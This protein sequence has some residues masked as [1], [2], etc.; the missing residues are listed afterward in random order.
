M[1]DTLIL[2]GHIA[3]VAQQLHRV[4]EETTLPP[5]GATAFLPSSPAKGVLGDPVEVERNMHVGHLMSEV[6]G[7]RPGSNPGLVARTHAACPAAMEAIKKED[8]N[9]ILQMFFL[10]DRHRNVGLSRSNG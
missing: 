3:E 5:R 10:L 7:A 9:K 4:L 6:L 8:K 2:T 1:R